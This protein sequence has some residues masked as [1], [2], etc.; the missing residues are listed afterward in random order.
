MQSL[1]RVRIID[2][3]VRALPG[4][5]MSGFGLSTRSIPAAFF[6]AVVHC[7][8]ALA[9]TLSAATQ[10][11]AAQAPA[12]DPVITEFLAANGT[13]LLDEDG[14]TSDW[15]EVHGPGPEAADL[16]GWYLTD[17]R[18]A[19]AKWRFPAVA[20]PAGG[21]LL[22]F[23]SG[24]DRADP[25]A[26]LHA[27]FRLSAGGEYLALVRPDGRTVSQE[28][29]PAFPPQRD[30]VA[31][32][33]GVRLAGDPLVPRGAACRILVPE[34]GP[35]APDWTGS[36]D[37]EPFDDSAW[38]EGRT[39]L[40]FD[41][42]AG[43]ERPILFFDFDDAS[44]AGLARD[45]SGGEHHGV[46]TSHLEYTGSGGSGRPGYTADGAGHTG[47]P[48]D[49]ALDFGL[50]GDGAMVAVPAAASGLFASAVE[51]DAVTIGLWILGSADQPAADVIFWGSSSPDGTGIRSL[52]AHVPW[53]DSVVYWDTAGCC[54]DTQ[55][56]S[57]PEP[58][59][60]RWKGRWNHWTFVKDGDSKRIYANGELF[61]E[62]E[63][64]SN[65]TPILG[66]FIGCAPR[67]G[68]MSYGGMVDDLAV[69]D[70]A[71]SSAQIASLAGGASP[72]ELS[73]YGH[74]IATDLRETMLGENASA[75]VRIP[76]D[77][78]DQ[79]NANALILRMHHEDGFVAWLNGVEVARRNAP[80][81]L[82]NDSRATATRSREEALEAEDVD[83]GAHIGLLR[84][85]RN[86]LAIHGLDEDP[87]GTSF[88][89][90]PELLLGRTTSAA[91][92]RPPT[93][94]RAN[95]PGFAG[96]VGDVR[97]DPERGYHDEP[98]D[99]T[100]TCDTEDAEVWYATDGSAPSPGAPGSEPYAGP[101][102]IATTA[103]LRAAAFLEDHEP[104]RIATHTYVLPAAI[105]KQPALPAG[106][107]SSWSGY[108]ADYQM[109]PD[110]VGSTLPG[111]GIEDA[112]LSIP[113]V[114][115]AL[116]RDDLWSPSGGIYANSS[117]VSERAASIEMLHPD[118][119]RG[120]QV[121]AGIRIHGYTSRMHDF[122][123]KHSF[124]VV[125]KR[126]YGPAKLDY[127]LFADSGVR[128]FDQFVLRGMSTDSWPVMDG[129]NGPE[130]GA[131]RWYRER[132]L[133]LREQWM[134]DS[135]LDMGQLSC[136]GIFVHVI[137]G[138]LY[139]GVYNLTER[140][141]DSFHAEH[142][143]GDK[144]EY[145]VLK[146][147]AEVQSGTGQAW[148]EMMALASAGLGSIA[149]Y[150]RI[151][152]NFPDGTP[153]PA[154][155]KYVDLEGLI[156]YMILHIYASADDWPNHNWWAGRRR[157]DESQ[158]FR[159]F[160]WDQEI[161]N[162][163]LAYHHTSWGP[164]YEEVAAYDSP[165]Y[166]YAQMR[167]NAE[168]RLQFGDRVQKHLFAG[169]ALTPE[170]SAARLTRRAEEID[171]AIVAE[172]ARWGDSK[173]SVPFKREVEWIAELD[174]LRDDYWPEL[175]PIALERFRRAGLYPTVA[176]PT[177]S[178]HGGTIVPGGG[179]GQEPGIEVFIS[180]PAGTVWF[181]DDGTD[182]RSPSDT[183]SA[184]ARAA[185]ADPVVIE[186]TTTLRARAR[187]EA[188]WSAL[189]EA[190]YQ[191]D[192]PLR[193]TE[194]HYHPLSPSDGSPF[195]DEDFEFIEVENVGPESVSLAG[196]RLLGAVRF[197]FS[198]GALASLEPRGVAVVV[199]DLQA[200]ASR[201]GEA[202]ARIAGA[203]EGELHNAGERIVLEGP[204]GETIHDFRYSDLWYPETDGGG[205]SLVIV[206]ALAAP[207]T[208]GRRA[209]WRPSAAAGGSPG[210]D[211]TAPPR[212]GLQAP[213]DFNQDSELNISD[214]VALLGYLFLDGSSPL[215]CAGALGEG[216]NAALLDSNGD[217]RVDLADAVH[218]LGFL[219]LGGPPHVL[220]SSCVRIEA[221][222]DACRG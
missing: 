161:T 199:R 67:S 206:D 105:A 35:W 47:R 112:I 68:E 212:G 52:N 3:G 66:F 109:D 65:L 174:R 95:A 191:V 97:F 57:R 130:P 82:R 196:V 4:S 31:Y 126:R 208:W 20:V 201:Y 221:C 76:F 7:L 140:P 189:T 158:G 137:L 98:F 144:E 5:E 203:Y 36:P 214:P 74:L 101:I 136:H 119:T 55:R 128:T 200:F 153:N 178:P 135:Q 160:P 25:A 129:W 185:G 21:Y 92:L 197:E 195:R 30:D 180:A 108:P 63:N 18:R 75:L 139:W 116:P 90:L 177:F 99:V 103:S 77:V 46:V 159:F 209:S 106:L 219:F 54:D 155:P 12:A 113:T 184:S 53:S 33:T 183:P 29:A 51:N 50:R 110:V 59:A 163:D 38:I 114:S 26:A 19:L 204:A 202:T 107:P 190:R 143:G 215:P 123:P 72:L 131:R 6:P 15:I 127:P 86:V 121:D 100:L 44:D 149:A 217:G 142:L 187:S 192:V 70:R 40:G 181:T 34:G 162:M 147:F 73:S 182:P 169:G 81:T 145:D 102:R 220:G 141:T 60:S 118:G 89:I 156:D 115:I 104:S 13:G 125:F 32:G 88:L 91:Y 58:D 171:R 11:P 188:V 39:G 173:R 157:G 138:G 211:E 168:F 78:P 8:S 16:E 24:K 205:P 1:E 43:E 61:L 23:A 122:T 165:S 218:A 2:P 151:Q 9:V 56:V 111:H 175:H 150:Q 117:Q 71:L 186:G 27:S 93:P 170:S 167:S 146:D 166:L 96:F 148:R 207:E 80:D 94:G 28:F 14:D 172:S 79:G 210:V 179:P 152:G 42:P 83:L 132:S 37:D 120:F 198:G 64:T 176:A 124:R 48:G 87:A 85:G 69:W 41:V 133:Y 193:V 216:G 49:R 213:G 22:V 154:Y 164:R 62:G 45:W 17:D 134:K 222:P 10:A 84:P 194:I